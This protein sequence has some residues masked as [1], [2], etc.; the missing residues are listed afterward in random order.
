MSDSKI[1]LYAN[2]ISK[3]LVREGVA[4]NENREDPDITKIVAKHAGISPKE[5]DYALSH[6]ASHPTP[7]GRG[8]NHH[9]YTVG[10]GGH[11]SENGEPPEYHT[12]N[13]STGETHSFTLP[14][15]RM[16]ANKIHEIMNKAIPGGV[17]REHARAVARDHNDIAGM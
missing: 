17:S 14:A 9:T 3:Q 2:Y 16:S 5:A 12:H 6:V 11:W 7:S 4:I 1:N 10:E 8:G 15:D 13:G